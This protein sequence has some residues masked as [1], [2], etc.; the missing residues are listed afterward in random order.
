[1]W[2]KE[3]NEEPEEIEI[4]WN[5]P[6]CRTGMLDG[7]SSSPDIPNGTGETKSKLMWRGGQCFQDSI[8]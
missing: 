4:T 7:E 3:F 2:H 8:I 6:K 1:M 5:E